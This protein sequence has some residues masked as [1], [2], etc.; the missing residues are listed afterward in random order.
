MSH[1]HDHA[2]HHHA[3]SSARAL[4]VAIALNLSFLILEAAVGWWTGSLALLADAGHMV[5]DVGAL[6]VALIAMRLGER[7]ANEHYT[8]GL[9]RAPVL[10]GLI[11]ALGLVVIVV[12]IVVEA[13]ERLSAPPVLDGRMIVAVGVAGLLV[14]LAS[15]WFLA[16]SADRSVNMRGAML[17]LLSDALGS[18]AAIISGVAMWAW[19]STLADPIA[20][21]II[22]L[23]ILLASA[24]LI[25]DTLRILL[26]RVPR[27]VALRDVREVLCA[28]PRVASIEA[29]HVWELDSGVPV[30][31]ATLR[32]HPRELEEVERLTASLREALHERFAMELVTLACRPA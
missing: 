32:V 14:N 15:A 21:V 24:P 9:R 12:M 4:Q 6:I 2:H 17:H 18:V 3:P 5:S 10:G 16:R 1:S 13:W 26:Q 22:A 11:N 28:D 27:G 7:A 31:S 19:S 8:Y 25:R 23:L 30:L 20:S 29:L